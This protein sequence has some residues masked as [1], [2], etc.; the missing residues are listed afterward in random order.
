MFAAGN[1]TS[2]FSFRYVPVCPDTTYRRAKCYVSLKPGLSVDVEA[3]CDN[4]LIHVTD[5]IYKTVAGL[6]Q[7]AYTNRG[8]IPCKEVC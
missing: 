4:T 6:R 3:A 5:L 1:F 7:P 2:D 8:T